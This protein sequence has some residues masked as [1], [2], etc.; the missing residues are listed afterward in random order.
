MIIEPQIF[1]LNLDNDNNI[2][3]IVI[4]SIYSKYKYFKY[5]NDSITDIYKLNFSN[6][7]LELII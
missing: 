5:K 7:N 2:P 6:N 3:F 1:F 4:N